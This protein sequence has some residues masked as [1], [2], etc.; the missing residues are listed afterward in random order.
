LFVDNASEG[1]AMSK[2][3]ISIVVVAVAA[4]AASTFAQ[5]PVRTPPPEPSTR[6]ASTP[7]PSVQVDPEV[8]TPAT[9]GPVDPKSKAD[10][11]PGVF[12]IP[13][14]RPTFQ[15][16]PVVL[17]YK[18]TDISPSHAATEEQLPLQRE[19]AARLAK[20]DFVPTLRQEHFR[21][22][23]NPEIRLVG[24]TGAVRKLTR[25][26][27]GWLVTVRIMPRLLTP[28][29]RLLLTEDHTMETYKYSNGTFNL[30]DYS[31]PGDGFQG[32]NRP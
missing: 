28:S 5:K 19:I 23:D 4:V 22:L 21:W 20:A 10:R 15:A 7:K 16:A 17:G 27:D 25:A 1:I 8:V 11:R 32:V 24:W 18:G 14:R 12:T 30:V 3:S 31:D 13:S 6:V 2:V 9:V 26:P 29:G